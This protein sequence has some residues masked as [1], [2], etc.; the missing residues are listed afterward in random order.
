MPTPFSWG[1]VLDFVKVGIETNWWGLSCPHHCGPPSLISLLISFLSGLS[2]GYSLDLLPASLSLSGLDFVPV[3]FPFSGLP[4]PILSCSDRLSSWGREALRL[5]VW[6]IL[7][8][9]FWSFRYQQLLLRVDIL[10][11][12]VIELESRSH[13]GGTE[14]FELVSEAPCRSQSGTSS[15]SSTYNSLATEI[16]PLPVSALQ[17]CANLRG[18]SYRQSSEQSVL[19]R[20]A[21]GA[22]QQASTILP[23]RLGQ[24]PPTLLFVPR[25]SLS[26]CVWRRLLTIEPY[27]ETLL[28]TAS[29]TALLRR[30]RP[31]CIAKDLA[32]LTPRR[33]TNGAERYCSAH[34][35]Q[36]RVV[37]VVLASRPQFGSSKSRRLSCGDGSTGL[38]RR[39]SGC[40][41]FSS[42]ACGVPSSGSYRG[43]YNWASH[44][45]G[46]ARRQII[47]YWKPA[48]RYR[49]RL[50]PGRLRSCSTGSTYTTILC[51]RIGRSR[52]DWVWRRLGCSP[53]SCGFG[54]ASSRIAISTSSAKGHLLL[55]GRGHRR[56]GD[57]RSS[58]SSGCA[59][60]SNR[61]GRHH[62]S[63]AFSGR[64]S[65]S[66]PHG[67]SAWKGAPCEGTHKGEEDY[68][69]SFG[70]ATDRADGPAPAMNRQIAEL[71]QGQVALQASVDQQ[72]MAP[73][74]RA[75]QMPIA[76]SVAKVSDFAKMMGGPPRTK[77]I[78]PQPVPPPT[79]GSGLDAKGSLQEQAEETSPI[80]HAG[81]FARAML[82]QSRAIMTLVASMQQGGDPLLDMPASSSGGSLGTRGSQGRERLQ[83]DL[84]TKSGNFFLA[85]LQN[86]AKRLRPAGARPASIEEVASTDFSMIHYLERFGGFGQFKELG[87]IQYALAHIFDALVHSDLN[88]AR[89]YLALLMV[90][91][92]QANLDNNRWELAYRMMLLEEPP[93]QLWAYRNQS[94]DPRSKSF[95][96]LA[97]QQWTTVALAYSKEMDYIQAKR[98]EVTQ[99]K[100]AATGAQPS[101]PYP[102]RRGRFPKAKATPPADAAP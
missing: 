66:S 77:A 15:N 85:V 6:V 42:S 18:G 4:G 50:A 69:C 83:R 95:S 79:M 48:V 10:E 53:R 35:G 38:W 71:Q 3:S 73:P 41:A 20:Q 8:L 61:S 43:R 91:V 72:R 34:S 31:G 97:P 44:Q 28:A 33:F 39:N 102:K 21:W 63:R 65:T 87:L 5:F 51:P 62:T 74:V 22:Y 11:R 58:H 75:S 25:E 96:P 55:C 101:N 49:Y 57:G 24:P 52:T 46:S 90:G 88:G 36:C 30:L 67:E 64:G 27:W 59:P 100:Q 7:L 81:P 93:S 19:G 56:A 47:G 68:Q 40:D 45:I 9:N 1:S 70:G 60:S 23:L 98:Q 32:S 99:P 13:H 82:E 78:L 29:P 14:E 17:L 16:L 80:A 12:K 94:Y 37:Q 2:L 76:A 84:A 92:D 54:G 26:L 89:D 86:A